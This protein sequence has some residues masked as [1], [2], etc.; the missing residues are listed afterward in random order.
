M[1]SKGRWTMSEPLYGEPEAEAHHRS[2][3]E[4]GV[5]KQRPAECRA[6]CLARRKK[7]S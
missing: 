3:L 6:G 2:G 5:K 1:P 7:E 4:L